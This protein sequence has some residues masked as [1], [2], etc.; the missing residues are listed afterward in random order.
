MGKDASSAHPGGASGGGGG[1]GDPNTKSKEAD[2][3]TLEFL[4]TVP[5]FRLWKSSLRKEVAGASVSPNEALNWICEIESAR[6]YMQLGD[7]GKFQTLDAK[8][9]SA[10]GKILH[11]DLGRR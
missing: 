8:L 4:P 1:G 6:D 7:S 9:A 2:K 5:K 3:I 11:G 10:F